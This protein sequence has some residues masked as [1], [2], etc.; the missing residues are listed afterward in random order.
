MTDARTS[1]AA[2]PGAL[3]DAA[4]SLRAFAAAAPRPLT[5]TDLRR[6]GVLMPGQALYELELTG[7][8]VTRVYG[9]DSSHR[10]TMLGYRL[11]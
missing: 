1:T 4:L 9:R 7:H 2:P 6:A 8:R 10:R 5:L 3:N 11:D